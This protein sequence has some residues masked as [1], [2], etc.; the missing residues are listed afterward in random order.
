MSDSMLDAIEKAIA[1]ALREATARIAAE[2]I[3]AAC[4]NVKRRIGEQIDSV[5]LG[6]LKQYEVWS[7]RTR[8][9]I[10]VRKPL[11]DKD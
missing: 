6:I 7:D 8:I 2:E 4:E 9:V 3:E 10:E 5:A 1:L 11:P